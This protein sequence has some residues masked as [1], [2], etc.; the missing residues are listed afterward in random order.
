MSLSVTP[1]YTH[2]DADEAYLV[3]QF[4]DRLREQLIETYGDEIIDMLK[5][6]NTDHH[7]DSDQIK[8]PFDDELPF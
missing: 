1:L 5:A 4:L 7:D 3:I 2:W 6:T 8:L